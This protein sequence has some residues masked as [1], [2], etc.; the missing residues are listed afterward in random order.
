[1]IVAYS[2]PNGGKNGN[3]DFR[4]LARKAVKHIHVITT[5]Y[6]TKNDGRV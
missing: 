3:S 4:F 6:T 1:M 2:P 5:S